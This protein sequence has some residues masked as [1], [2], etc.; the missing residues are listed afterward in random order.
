MDDITPGKQR[1]AI[2][3]SIVEQFQ[4]VDFTQSNHAYLEDD[5]FWDFV[6]SWYQL[7]RYYELSRDTAIGA[8]ML[9]LFQQCGH[10]FRQAATD[11]SLRERRRDK[12]ADAIRQMTYYVDRMIKEA[13]RNGKAKDKAVGNLDWA[14]N[15]DTPDDD[16]PPFSLN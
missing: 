14:E 16:A 4:Q 5:D 12:A 7:V 11:S 3:D 8:H 10:K 15:D 2:E 6:F 1:H 13:E 9:D